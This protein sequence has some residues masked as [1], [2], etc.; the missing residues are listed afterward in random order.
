MGKTIGIKLAD[1]TFYP[2]V[3]T[4][5][6]G[7]KELGLTTVQ[8]NQSE[9]R[10][11]LYRGD[12]L[13]P[14]TVEYLDTLRLDQLQP[15]PAGDLDIDLTLTLDEDD[16]FVVDLFDPESGERSVKSI[17]HVT[18]RGAGGAQPMYDL[19]GTIERGQ[20]ELDSL[21]DMDEEISEVGGDEATEEIGLPFDDDEVTGSVES[22]F[23]DEESVS[24]EPFTPIEPAASPVED[25]LKDLHPGEG[26]DFDFGNGRSS[27]PTEAAREHKAEPVPPISDA[28]AKRVRF[29]G[30]AVVIIFIEVLVACFVII[31]PRLMSDTGSRAHGNYIVS[32]SIAPSPHS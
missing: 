32:S 1:D 8:E 9:V 31:R 14:G 19:F 5:S 20:D 27:R 15:H 21:E 7:T 24:E 16:L 2:I 28:T 22:L 25:L 6:P 18:S 17:P 13:A 30:I 12:D 11:D 26:P 29:I 23:V 10:V 4:D 3:S